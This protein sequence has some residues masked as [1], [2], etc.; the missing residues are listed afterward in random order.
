MASRIL[1]CALLFAVACGGAVDVESFDRESDFRI[2]ERYEPD[3]YVT[4]DGVHDYMR[5]DDWIKIRG[6]DNAEG[7]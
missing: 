1:G 7:R 5:C 3:V 2:C 6:V 4:W